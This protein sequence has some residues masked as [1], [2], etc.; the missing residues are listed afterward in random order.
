M[1]ETLTNSSALQNE[2]IPSKSDMEKSRQTDT[3]AQETDLT[4]DTSLKTEDGS[5]GIKTD[6]AQEGDIEP[7][8]QATANAE[9]GI[10][11][12]KTGNTQEDGTTS[13]RADSTQKDGTTSLL[14]GN[15]QNNGIADL[16]ADN[17]QED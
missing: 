12:S 3:T 13:L 10:A 7:V 17:T 9:E 15:A 6:Q 5:A 2:E 16:H 8:K 11:G 14:T 4:G 1:S